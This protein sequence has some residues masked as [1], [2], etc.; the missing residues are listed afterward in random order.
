MFQFEIGAAVSDLEMNAQLKQGLGE[1]SFP[2]SI[3]IE[4]LMPIPIV[5]ATI[6]VVSLDGNLKVDGKTRGEFEFPTFGHLARF[7]DNM[8]TI[9]K[10]NDFK[11]AILISA[12]TAESDE[13]TAVK[14]TRKS[15][16]ETAKDAQDVAEE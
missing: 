11:Q 16:A 1:F 12:E 14:K 7:A 4:N 8:L 15:K 6:G 2:K 13:K 3:M 10:L 9:A 5:D